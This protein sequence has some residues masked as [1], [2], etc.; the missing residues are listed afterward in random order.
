MEHIYFFYGDQKKISWI[1]ENSQSRS[2]ESRVHA[3]YF[4]DIVTAEQSKYI[5]LHV[6][7]FWGIGRFI[8]KN[9]D[10]VN[11]MLDQRSMFDRLAENKLTEDVFIERRIKF[12]DQIIKQR[13]LDVRYQLVDPSKNMATKLLLS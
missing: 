9:G 1:I 5:A 8:I 12:I 3:E 4:Y 7:I 2:E 13:D 11:V 6:G 10:V